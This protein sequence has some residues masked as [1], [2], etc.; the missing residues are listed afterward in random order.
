MLQP[1]Q[2]TPRGGRN[3][4]EFQAANQIEIPAFVVH[5]S[6][7]QNANFEIPAEKVF[8]P[9]SQSQEQG[10]FVGYMNKTSASFFHHFQDDLE[11]NKEVVA[12]RL[13]KLKRNL[14][15]ILKTDISNSAEETIYFS[16][17]LFCL[18]IEN[19]SPEEIKSLET[20]HFLS[21]QTSS[22]NLLLDKIN[23]LK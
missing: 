23:L 4:I 17:S 12:K 8:I 2:R 18:P 11:V 16:S 3:I 15:R 13:K 6:F 19:V 1:P 14:E 20:L 5:Y 21:N 10:H 22:N 9:V 7:D